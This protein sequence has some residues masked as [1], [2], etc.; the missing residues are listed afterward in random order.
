MLSSQQRDQYLILLRANRMQAP[1][2]VPHTAVRQEDLLST[3]ALSW[4]QSTAAVR[5][6]Q[7]HREGRAGDS[8]AGNSRLCCRN[9]R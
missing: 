7:R 2:V 9:K 6:R 3:R 5:S 8:E 1:A 4:L